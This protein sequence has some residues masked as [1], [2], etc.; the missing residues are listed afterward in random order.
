[1][2]LELLLDRSGQIPTEKH[3]GVTAMAFG[4]Q[5]P[6]GFIGRWVQDISRKEWAQYRLQ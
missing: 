1:M 6:P 5:K 3:E 4:V 2:Q